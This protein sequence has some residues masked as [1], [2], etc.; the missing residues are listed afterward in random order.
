M[1]PTQIRV[2]NFLSY[3]DSG[4]INLSD[5][6]ILVGENNA[7]K[8]NFVDAV[9]EFFRFSNRARQD[10]NNFY[11]RDEDREI[12]ITV[13]FDGL[14]DEEKEEFSNGVG[15]PEDAEL[16]VRVVSEYNSK[17][18][19]AETND[20]QQLITDDEESGDNWAKTTGL[21]N[22]LSNRLP[23]VSHYG[24]EREL[25]DAAKTSNKSSLLYKLLGAAYDDIPRSVTDEFEDD[26]DRLKQ[27]LEH[28][29]PEAIEDLTENLSL[30]MN[31]QVSIDGDLDIEFEMPT[32]KEMI[33]RHATIIAGEDQEN[34]LGDMGSGSKMSF[35]LSCIWEVANRDTDDVFLTLEEP[36]NYLHPHSIRELH[37]TLDELA[38]GGDFVIL[39]THSPELAGPRD[40]NSIRRVERSNGS[41]RIKQPSDDLQ[42]KDVQVL[43]TIESSET[44]EIFFSRSLIIC[45]GPSDRDVLQIANDLLTK[46]N[47]EVRGFDAE[48]VSV[49]HAQGKHNVPKYLR[50]AK[51]FGIPTIAVLDTDINRDDGYGTSEI[52]WGTI[53]ESRSLSDQFVMLEKD[54]ERALFEE[55]PLKKFHETMEHLSEIGVIREYDRTLDDLQ[56]EKECDPNIDNKTDLFVS[57]F[58]DYDPSKPA[59]GRELARQCEVESFP[60]RLQHIVENA[61]ELAG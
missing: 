38:G 42:E 60:D 27:K 29:T 30:M 4:K 45:E 13:W 15:D 55:I 11:N 35:I 17:E 2:E 51:E 58:D 18:N 14:T 8:S 47:P 12:R 10:L 52:D 25:D 6:T 61:V 59:L 49:V 24:A 40:L 44:K 48:G 21:A 33:Q 46:G 50:V 7:G 56:T 54:L 1:Y 3:E 26:R 19:R 9:R 23:D 34:T 39:T 53:R 5:K 41:S 57:Y 22:A 36:E 20:Y 16:A 37:A 32:V 28:D 31:R 43:E